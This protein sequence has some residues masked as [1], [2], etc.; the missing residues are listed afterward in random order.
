MIKEA[1]SPF[2]HFSHH[3]GVAHSMLHWQFDVLGSVMTI[4]I[5]TVVVN[6]WRKLAGA[7]LGIFVGY[8]LAYLREYRKLSYWMY[9]LCCDPRIK[10]V[11]FLGFKEGGAVAQIAHAEFARLFPDLRTSCHAIGSPR[12]VTR[13][14][15]F[16]FRP[17]VTLYEYGNDAAT[18][19]PPL[20]YARPR[21][22]VIKKAGPKRLFFIYSMRDSN[23]ERYERGF[24]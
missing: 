5:S 3:R 15:G 12:C 4:C 1:L 11:V 6:R 8:H 20:L 23:K 18:K 16:S 24:I 21:A 10:R 19:L 14:R 7:L 2:Q 9:H 17:P 13:M 22:A